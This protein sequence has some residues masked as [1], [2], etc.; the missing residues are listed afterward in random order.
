MSCITLFLFQDGSLFIGLTDYNKVIHACKKQ[1]QKKQT[2][3]TEEQEEENE[4]HLFPSPNHYRNNT[5]SAFRCLSL[6][7]LGSVWLCVPVFVFNKVGLNCS[8]TTSCIV[9]NETRLFGAPFHVRY[10][11]LL[12]SFNSNTP[13]HWILKYINI[14]LGSGK[15]SLRF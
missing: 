14:L 11:D 9:F 12:H 2:H 8:L 6:Q 3:S 5:R 13:F 15:A 10:T 1:Q 4:C 7:T